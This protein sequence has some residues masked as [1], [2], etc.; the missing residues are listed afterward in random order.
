MMEEPKF[1]VGDLI[2]HKKGYRG[3]DKAVVTRV[4]DKNY[5]LKILCGTA[6]LPIGAQVNYKLLNEE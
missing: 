3:L 2:I 1:K 5:Y 6:V 4:D